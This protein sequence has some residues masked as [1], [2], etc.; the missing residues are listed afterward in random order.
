MK[1]RAG[2]RLLHFL[3]VLGTTLLVGTMNAFGQY[4]GH[5]S[6]TATQPLTPS[7]SYYVWA[8]CTD[9]DGGY[10]NPCNLQYS[11]SYN[12]DSGGH[13]HNTSRQSSSV[14]PSSGNAANGQNVQITTKAWAQEEC[15]EAAPAG[16]GTP[17]IVDYIVGNGLPD[18]SLFWNGEHTDIWYLT[19][20]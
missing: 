14:S 1:S 15:F 20:A 17:G 12:P 6:L 5:A 4:I 3:V 13:F 10:V 8:T 9:D 16:G 19:G 7:T 11:T 18:V 2:I